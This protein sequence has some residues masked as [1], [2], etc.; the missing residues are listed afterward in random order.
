MIKS[1]ELSQSLKYVTALSLLPAYLL[2]FLY[3]LR[4]YQAMY[5]EA[6]SVSTENRAIVNHT[7]L[8]LGGYRARLHYF[9]KKYSTGVRQLCPDMPPDELLGIPGW[10]RDYDPVAEVTGSKSKAAA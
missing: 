5:R 2:A 10:S 6:S 7:N 4:F 1:F 9:Y 8:M 3:L